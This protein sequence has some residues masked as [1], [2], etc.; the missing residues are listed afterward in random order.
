[1]QPCA[2]ARSASSSAAAPA[3]ECTGLMPKEADS[4]TGRPPASTR[5]PPQPIITRTTVMNPYV[6]TAKTVPDSLTPRRFITV[7]TATK[8]SEIP[9]A[10]GRSGRKAEVIASTPAATETATVS[11]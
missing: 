3:A 7:S 5:Q 9:V 4:A 6:G 10:A 2:N 8:P 11:T 1:V